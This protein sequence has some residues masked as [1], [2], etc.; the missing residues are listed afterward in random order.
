MTQICRPGQVGTGTSV[1]RTLGCNQ[2]QDPGYSSWSGRLLG[3]PGEWP[4]LGRGK[5][6]I[7][8]GM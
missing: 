8:G 2:E 4:V 1:I 6:S 7:R 5:L 3:G